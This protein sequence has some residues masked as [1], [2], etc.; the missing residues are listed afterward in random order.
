MGLIS[1]SEEYGE[2]RAIT[3]F[4]EDTTFPQINITPAR[5][6]TLYDEIYRESREET[7]FFGF[8]SGS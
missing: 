1:N 4:D 3:D 7:S 6:D 5:M 8:F 2:V